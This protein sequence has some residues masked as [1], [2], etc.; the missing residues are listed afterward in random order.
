MFP[1]AHAIM[2]H[3]GACSLFNNIL[4][5]ADLEDR[6]SIFFFLDGVRP[7]WDEEETRN[8]GIWQVPI[9][10]R[11]QESKAKLESYWADAVRAR[12]VARRRMF[13]ICVPMLSR[14]STC[15]CPSRCCKHS[16]ES[17]MCGT[18]MWPNIRPIGSVCTSSVLPLQCKVYGYQPWLQCIVAAAL[19]FAHV[20]TGVAFAGRAV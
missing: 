10:S 3:A 18:Y 6:A 2:L 15:R 20:H 5:P 7:D 16:K 11:G 14:S 4:T 19:T 1:P 17:I 13:P 9:K 12:S 8:G